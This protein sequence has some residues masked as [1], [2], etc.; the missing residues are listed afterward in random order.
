MASI[1]A[2]MHGGR[3]YWCIVESKRINGKPRSTVIEYLGT[4]DTL[5]A[6]LK[7]DQ[8]TS[9]VKSFSHG[10]VAAL[11]SLAKKLDVVTTINKFTSS[12]REYWAEQPI[13]NDLTA[14]ITLLLA[15]TG[16]ICEPTSK[17]GWCTWAEKTSCDHLLR[18]SLSNLDSQ[19]FWDLMDCIPEDAI[20]KIELEILQKVLKYYP[21]NAGTLLYDTTNIFT[22][23]D[24][25]NDRCDIAQRGK[26]KQKRSDLR[27]VGLALVVT[28]EDYIPLLHYTYQG[29]ISDCKVF[30]KIIG[31][32][33]ERMETLKM[34]ISHHTIVF[35]RGCNSKNNLKKIKRLKLHYIGALTPY[36]HKDL[37]E[38]ADGNF[39]NIQV[40]DS[41]LG[42][43]REKREIWGEE[44]TVLV[45]ISEK[46]KAGQLRGVYQSLE[47]KR[48]RLRKI[49][50]ALS[51][52]KSKK[53]TKEALKKTIDK[54]LKGQFMEG[55]ID[56]ELTE[57]KEPNELKECQWSLTYSTNQKRLSQIE[58]RFGFRIIMTS[59]HDWESNN[60][61]KAFYG[62]ATVEGAFKNIKNPYHLAIKPGF[63][64]TTHKIKIHYFICV[65]GYLL[66]TL[67][68]HEARKIGFTGTLDNLLDSLNAIRLSRQLEL[69]GKQG[70]PKVTYQ[71]EEMSQEQESLLKALNVHEIHHKPLKIEGVRE[72][73]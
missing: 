34:D 65:L 73:I 12:Q 21:L 55:L 48:K 54:V 72:Y 8:G 70:K 60:I 30:A 1:Q 5:L 15:S 44:R 33:K 2:K 42:V 22:F 24:S 66:S 67:I 6:R 27:Q 68:W 23:I 52:P 51:N 25:T 37:I 49:Q 50:R 69:S 38:V 43:Y 17:R 32:I 57:L 10:C 16:R 13:R 39:T 11:L 35:D 7:K 56:Y 64:W 47:N 29:N 20:E 62:Q 41:Q 28:Q 31:N 71:L 26:N 58:D 18:I 40:G 61:I 9:K 3:K 36:H 59:R 53:R 63:H 19:H 46:L 4:A 14:G 45:F